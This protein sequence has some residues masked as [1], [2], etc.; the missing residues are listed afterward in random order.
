MPLGKPKLICKKGRSFMET[1][2]REVVGHI[3]G[4]SYWGGPTETFEKT[5]IESFQRT[6]STD[7]LWP[8]VRKFLDGRYDNPS[9]AGNTAMDA[10]GHFVT[11]FD[12]GHYFC[13]E[14]SSVHSNMHYLKASG[15]YSTLDYGLEQRGAILFAGWSTPNSLYTENE[16]SQRAQADF[17]LGGTAISRARPGKPLIDLANT[18]GELRTE[19]L[20]KMFGSMISRA[21]TVRELFRR[22]GDEYL[23]AQFGW[24]PLM[25][26]VTSLAQLAG[27]SRHILERYESDID[28]LIRRRYHFDDIINTSEFTP[29]GHEV[30]TLGLSLPLFSLRHGTSGVVPV[31][32]ER[33]VTK[34]YFSGGFRFY[35]PDFP[36]AFE[37]LTEIEKQ[38]NA[39]LG[40]RLDPEVL[41][42]LQPWTWMVDWFVNIGDILGNISAFTADNL[43]M[44]Y[45][46][47]MSET[48][49]MQEVTYPAI[50]RRVNT[51]TWQR[52]SG[53]LSNIKYKRRKMRSKASPFGFGLNPDSFTESQWAI[54]GALGMSH[55][56]K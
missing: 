18:I 39:L 54:L 45:G 49:W 11:H 3:G 34:S 42:N 20:P 4:T 12:W 52:V 6:K 22:G 10:W 38:A 19:G 16:N 26:D 9:I 28:K 31:G 44:Q 27:Q 55:G 1:K 51:S 33:T 47:I 32:I 50:F 8:T 36:S 40:T 35:Y 14:R 43:V 24:A 7:G 56:L 53:P 37:H 48:E 15:R 21:S 5:Y 41:W 29:I 30:G 2:Y 23:N 25:R 46:Y 17:S 13:T